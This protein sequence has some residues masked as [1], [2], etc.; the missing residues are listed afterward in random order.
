MINEKPRRLAFFIEMN[1][2][3]SSLQQGEYRL[4]FFTMSMFKLIRADEVRPDLYLKQNRLSNPF[5]S[6]SRTLSG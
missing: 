1:F 3:T 5:F 6:Y 2:V 4:R